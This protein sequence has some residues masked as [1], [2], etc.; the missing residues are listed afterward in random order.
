ME[1][2]HAPIA[3]LSLAVA[4]RL[5]ELDQLRDENAEFRAINSRQKIEISELRK[6]LQS[7][8]ARQVELERKLEKQEQKKLEKQHPKI[9][10]KSE[11]TKKPISI[12]PIAKQGNSQ[13]KRK[14]P[15]PGPTDIKTSSPKK[16]RL[17]QEKLKGRNET[18]LRHK[19]SS[20]P[21]I[22]RQGSTRC[23]MDEQENDQVVERREE[24][25]QQIAE[26]S[27]D[28]GVCKFCG[29]QDC[30]C[31]EEMDFSV[32]PPN[33]SRYKSESS[34]SS[35]SRESEK[36]T[37]LNVTRYPASDEGESEE[38]AVFKPKPYR[39][40]NYASFGY[41]KFGNDCKFS[42]GDVKGDKPRG[43][44]VRSSYLNSEQ[45]RPSRLSNRNQRAEKITSHEPQKGFIPHK[46]IV[47]IWFSGLP[48]RTT[49]KTLL[50]ALRSHLGVNRIG[51]SNRVEIVNGRCVVF[52][53]EGD[54]AR[55]LMNSLPFKVF[56]TAVDVQEER[57]PNQEFGAGFHIYLTGLP[58]KTSSKNLM[59][60]LRSH[61]N[62][63]RL[64]IR[65]RVQ[66]VNGCSEIWFNDPEMANNLLNSQP[67]KVFDRVIDVS[68]NP[69]HERVNNHQNDF[70]GQ[71]LRNLPDIRDLQVNR[72][73]RRYDSSRN[74]YDS[75]L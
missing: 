30:D 25:K 46:P 57:A 58:L 47:R 60:A 26:A 31:S 12:S 39:C 63:K 28:T 15:S 66:Q 45:P 27:K 38:V 54:M 1:E 55:K 22:G 7:V 69:W 16:R 56:N 42:H 72:H 75:M 59:G 68:R 32:A 43:K 20:S 29:L 6:A 3:G 52:F 61:L 49:N 8:V 67:F 34:S 18:Q 74:R 36:K 65:N 40:K 53:D 50:G 4:D 17:Q 71:D 51:L 21:K 13:V 5:K 23:N 62:V 35:S 41:C 11:P 37:S 33:P 64:P 24:V 73:N 9:R 19:E 44:P 14:K 70:W 2:D 48:I 10:I